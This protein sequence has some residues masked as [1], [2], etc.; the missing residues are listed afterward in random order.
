MLVLVASF[1]PYLFL[2]IKQNNFISFRYVSVGDIAR[3]GNHPPNVAAVYQ[4]I[5]KLFALPVGY[6]LVWRN[7][8]DDYT[9]PV[10]IWYPRA[11]EGFIS[12]GCVAVPGFEEPEPDLVQCV[13]E[14]ILEETTFE[15]Q[16][17]WSAPESYPWGCH[18][19]QVKSEA[20][21]FVALRESKEYKDWK[22]RKIPDH[23]QPQQSLEEAH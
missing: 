4:S 5:D 18:V 12:L 3:V 1:P 7:C 11:P 17:I 9:T 10:S 14:V 13:A 15:E 2:N 20:L 23:F 22:P 21:H 16:K 19:Y 6:D 8:M